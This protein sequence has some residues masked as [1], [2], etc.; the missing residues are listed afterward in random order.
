MMIDRGCLEDYAQPV[1]RAKGL[2]ASRLMLPRQ[3]K[4]NDET[5]SSQLRGRYAGYCLTAISAT[6]GEAIAV[7][8]RH[9]LPVVCLTIGHSA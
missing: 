7:R 2:T 1:H 4:T 6:L 3:T 9:L 8:C 5:F